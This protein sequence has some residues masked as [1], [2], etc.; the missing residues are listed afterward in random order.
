M[1]GTSHHASSG[2]SRRTPTL[3]L[4]PQG[5]DPLPCQST[6]GHPTLP[7]PLVR[8]RRTPLWRSPLDDD[9][10]LVIVAKVSAP[11]LF[12]SKTS[13]VV[14]QLGILLIRGGTGLF[15]WLTRDWLVFGSIVTLHVLHHDLRLGLG[16]LSHLYRCSAWPLACN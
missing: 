12:P 11:D 13:V 15:D 7:V 6:L 10:V 9:P 14:Y 3:W 5:G 2:G 1:Y 8:A 16:V 4:P